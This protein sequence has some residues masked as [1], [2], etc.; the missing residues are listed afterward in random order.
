MRGP[1]GAHRNFGFGAIEEKSLTGYEIPVAMALASA[2]TGMAG[3]Q[4]Q[5]K[6]QKKKTKLQLEQQR[7]QLDQAE[8][9]EKKETQKRRAKA[10]AHFGA[11]G[12]GGTGGSAD[13]VTRGMR[14]E[15]AQRLK[16]MR[17]NAHFGS[18]NLLLAD[19]ASASNYRFGQIGN[20]LNGASSA[21]GA[22]Q[23]AKEQK[24]RME[25][26]KEGGSNK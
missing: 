16:D 7:A 6:M 14:A 11:A 18:Q 4:Q 19:Q 8:R 2:A 12:I 26:L 17:E 1:I 22:Y 15:S 9:K 10:F 20:L 13:A 24:M 5:R 23:D 3:A 25:N 21:Y